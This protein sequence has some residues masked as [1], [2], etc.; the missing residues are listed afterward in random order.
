MASERSSKNK[1]ILLI[2]FTLI[3]F[4]GALHLLLINTLQKNPTRDA[5]IQDIKTAFLKKYPNWDKPD[6]FNVIIETTSP[7]HAMGQ[8]FWPGNEKH[9]SW[10]V[11]K[12]N[13]Q[14]TITDYNGGSYF[15]ICQN[16]KKYNFPAAITPDCWDEDQK[17]VINTP[18]P[19][20]FYNG[21][22]AEDK[23]NIILAFLKYEQNG[24]NFIDQNLYV[25]FDEYIDEYLTGAILLGGTDNYSTPYFLAVKTG[26]DWK[27]LYW[28]QESPPCKNITGYNVP[29]KMIPSC[30]SDN[31]TEWIKR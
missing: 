29:N 21:L 30:Y 22:T 2:I 31:G 24:S 23:T 10:F 8:V 7:T 19:D 28:G 15:G 1:K 4:I 25:K 3:A 14:W 26:N 9:G 12:I 11:V 5:T 18:D 17:I 6:F 20:R 13:N 27:V 16:F